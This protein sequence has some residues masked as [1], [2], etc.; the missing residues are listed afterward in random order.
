MHTELAGIL[1]LVNP[2]FINGGMPIKSMVMLS[3]KMPSQFRRTQ[4][5]K[6]H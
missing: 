6:R 4:P 1:E 2:D 5:I 3:S